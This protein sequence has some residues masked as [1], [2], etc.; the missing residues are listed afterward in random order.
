MNSVLTFILIITM[1]FYIVVCN[2]QWYG[3]YINVSHKFILLHLNYLKYQ[4]IIMPDE[5]IG[6]M[7]GMVD[8]ADLSTFMVGIIRITMVMVAIITPDIITITTIMI[9]DYNVFKIKLY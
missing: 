2:P 3:K 9:T 7:A 8:I 5:G 4:V 1:L 6:G